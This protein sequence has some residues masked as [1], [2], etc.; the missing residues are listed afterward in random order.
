[1]KQI[2]F[3]LWDGETVRTGHDNAIKVYAKEEMAKRISIAM[4][5]PYRA[6]FIDDGGAPVEE[7][8]AP[9]FDEKTA[10]HAA[11]LAGNAGTPKK[12]DVEWCLRQ[13]QFARNSHPTTAINAIVTI[14]NEMLDP[15]GVKL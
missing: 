13:L 12:P 1:M 3:I 2:G 11:V 9:L 5:I 6:V 7:F 14:L 4:G 15:N 8:D 10:R